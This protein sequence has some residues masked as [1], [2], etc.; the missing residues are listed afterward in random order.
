MFQFNYELKAGRRS[1]QLALLVFECS[2]ADSVSEPTISKDYF[3]PLDID[4]LEKAD[5][6]F[7]DF[8]VLFPVPIPVKT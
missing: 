7:Q 6:L 8:H 3:V 4:D 1:K 2:L 5:F